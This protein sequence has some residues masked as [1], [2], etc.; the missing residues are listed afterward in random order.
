[1]KKASRW[2]ICE[3]GYVETFRAIHMSAARA[4][5]NNFEDDWPSFEVIDV[6]HLLAVE[7]AQIAVHHRV[8]SLDALHLAAAKRIPGES[9]VVAT[10]DTQMRRACAELS[11][12]LFPV[13]LP[14]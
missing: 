14:A 1:M 10:W 3:I 13:E 5:T 8:R 4:S 12:D 2:F 7:A 9:V 6:D 11:L